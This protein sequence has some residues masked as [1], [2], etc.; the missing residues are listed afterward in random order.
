MTLPAPY[1]ADAA[2][3][4]YHGDC[5]EIMPA[6]PVADLIV[7]DPPYGLSLIGER[8]VGQAGCGVRTL[9]FFPNDTLAD[10]FAHVDTILSAA[11]T[12]PQH[13][14]VYA[15]LGHHQF[16]KATLAFHERGWQSACREVEAICDV[17][18]A[19]AAE[20][21][22]TPTVPCSCSRRSETVHS[23]RHPSRK[24]H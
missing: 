22:A 1:Y 15:W 8:H 6:L 12:L 13:G 17:C 7:T 9:D 3:T 2:V 4:L 18:R 21:I 10:G 5:R 19:C 14:A 20:R 11:D 16:A 23:N 24:S